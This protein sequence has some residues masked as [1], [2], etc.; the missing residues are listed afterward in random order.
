[1]P[2]PVILIIDLNIAIGLRYEVKNTNWSNR[3]EF[4]RYSLLKLF[5]C[6]LVLKKQLKGLLIVNL[7]R[8][9]NQYYYYYYCSEPGSDLL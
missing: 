2:Y 7:V 6:L 3:N 1:M 5:C 9:G 4:L 8:S